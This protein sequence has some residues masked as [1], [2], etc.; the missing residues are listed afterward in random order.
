MFMFVLCIDLWRP[1]NQLGVLSPATMQL[2]DECEEALGLGTFYY[3]SDKLCI[4]SDKLLTSYWFIHNCINI[5]LNDLSICLKLVRV[6][7]M[8][9]SVAAEKWCAV[10]GYHATAGRM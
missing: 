4:K 8:Y 2:L 3:L 1:D 7:A 5:D 10:A 9:R 6:C